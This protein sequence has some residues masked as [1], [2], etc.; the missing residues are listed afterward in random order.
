MKNVPR[1]PPLSA[2]LSLLFTSLDGSTISNAPKND[3]AKSM[4]T[5]K[6]TMFGSQWVANQLNMSAV[7]A[8][9]PTILVIRIIREIGTV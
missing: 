2:P 7:T 5:M 1:S 8:S 4:N 3:A 6:N 9:P